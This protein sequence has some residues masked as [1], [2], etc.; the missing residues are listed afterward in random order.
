ML[1]KMKNELLRAMEEY[2]GRDAKR[3]FHAH[4]VLYYAEKIMES[5]RAN[6]DVVTAA[7]ILHDI[8]IHEAERKYD[9]TAGHY[10][11][12]E[13]P[14]IARQILKKLDATDE[15][16]ETVCA[17]VGKH[18]TLN[19]IN[20]PEFQVLYEAD[21]IVNLQDDFK[22]L[23]FEKKKKLIEKNIQTAIGTEIAVKKIGDK[24]C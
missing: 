24:V 4:Q 15:F 6:R 2:F 22:D 5:E 1:G 17:M 21:W 20:T 8:G 11:Q 16:I 19:G 7:A 23:D 9:S 18:H 12:I 10:Q 14:P 13:G 3:I